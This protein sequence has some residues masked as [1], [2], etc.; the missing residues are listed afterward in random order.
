LSLDSQGEFLYN[1]SPK[2]R[3]LQPT[4][5]EK[6]DKK[7]AEAAKEGPVAPPEKE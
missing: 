4:E 5:L 3:V 1:F 6:L 7:A 2:K